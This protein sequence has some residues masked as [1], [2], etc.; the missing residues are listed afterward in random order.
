M[1]PRRSRSVETQVEARQADEGAALRVREEAGHG[2]G[3]PDDGDLRSVLNMAGDYGEQDDFAD[4]EVENLNN[5]DVTALPDAPLLGARSPSSDMWGQGAETAG[6]ATSPR[7][8]AQASNFPT[9]TQFRVWRWENGVPVALGAID[10]EATEDDFVR[11]FFAAMPQDGDGRFQFRCRPVDIRG[12]ELG[13]EFTINIS[14]HHSALVHLRRRQQRRQE[15]ER[16]M[17]V[18]HHGSPGQPIIVNPAPAGDG[19]G[20]LAEEM[21]RLFESTLESAERRAQMYE[22]SLEDERDR[23]RQEAEKRA[24]ERVRM[25]STSAETVQKM[26]E[27]LMAA[28]R[29]RGEEQLG[30]QREQSQ[31]LVSTLTTVFQQQQVAAREQAER[32]REA[33]MQRMSQDREFFARHQQEQEQV[34]LRERA[35]WERRQEAERARAE[36]EVKR[37]EAQRA[38]ELEQMRLEA[39]KQ[40][41]EANA[42]RD[43]ERA[44][45]AL[46]I[47]QAKLEAERQRQQV[48]EE[49]ER[50]RVEVEERR[51]QDREEW[52]RKQALLRE[53]Y[54]RQRQDNDRRE[55]IRREE[56][57]RET[58]RR[59]E[60]L[61]MQMKQLDVQA[62]RDREHQEKMM[63]MARLEREGQREAMQARERAEAEARQLAEAERQRQH[64]LTMREM[65]IS[66]ERDREHAERMVQM[67]KLQQTGG[68]GQIGEMLGMETPELLQR[69]FGGGGGDDKGSGWADAVP[70]ILGSMAD[71]GK[72]VL[73][74]KTAAGPA[75]PRRS[76]PARPASPQALMPQ[77]GGAAA[78]AG[79]QMVQIQTSEGP[80]IIPLE[81]AQRMGFVPI[82]QAG[83]QQ[84]AQIAAPGLP[85]RGFVPP[86][87]RASV[88]RD[89]QFQQMLSEANEVP[90]HLRPLPAGEIAAAPDD[91]DVATRTDTTARSKEAGIS[92]IDLRKARKS[93]RGLVDSLRNAPEDQWE[94]L[95]TGAIIENVGI[96][97]YIQAVTFYAAVAEAGADRELAHRIAA[98]LR[99]STMVPDDLVYTEADLS[100]AKAAP[101]ETA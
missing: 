41:V 61:L 46:R 3:E 77:A 19:S 47:E 72:A 24:E 42:R 57:Q 14:E 31:M 6:R 60:E 13:K 26:M 28:D 7:L 65:E 56:V 71:V 5:P 12:Q 89:P 51:R 70:K 80:R 76:K 83:Q 18:H 92:L 95:V 21:G 84:T 30:A 38:F 82:E 88:R 66:K 45:V 90:L 97:A 62:Q 52:E 50:W 2:F 79:Q 100:A 33:D 39:Q 8:Y 32:L 73:A 69:I 1:P 68:F 23:M 35:E 37:M 67:S 27:R 74:G 91:F 99:K 81:M 85:E 15:S 25:A 20:H 96:F 4:A 53:D 63:E 54:E 58:E 16:D 86:E 22:R 43:Q 17:S 78:A 10:V 49:R 36:Q 87:P 101:K 11:Q 59:K 40:Q 93:L 75:E 9:A 55:Q 44:E 48:F 94:A 34:R 98:A 29:S 64:A